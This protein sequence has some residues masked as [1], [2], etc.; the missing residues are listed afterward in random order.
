MTTIRTSLS[1]VLLFLH[2]ACSNS[3]PGLD[4]PAKALGA[5]LEGKQL[6]KQTFDE[7]FREFDA[8]PDQAAGPA[9]HRWRTVMGYGGPAAFDNRKISVT[10]IGVDSDFPGV[11]EGRLRTKTLGLNPFEHGEDKPL[12][13][14]ARPT[15]KELLPQLWGA[16]YYSG[17]ITTKFSFSQRYGY[18]EVEAK[19]PK[20]KGMWPSFWLLPVSAQWPQGGEIDVFEGL[21]DARSIYTTLHWGKQH[22]QTQ[23]K[24]D[25]PFDV[26]ADFHRYGVAWTRDAIVWY[27]DRREVMRTP[28]PDEVQHP[29]FLLLNLG[30]GG[31]WG[32]YPDQSTTFPGRYSIRRV[33]VWTL[34]GN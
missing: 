23:R 17:Q 25:L 14:L 2:A 30:V 27:V 34:S 10:S 5:V 7:T 11:E 4:R 8:G 26:S 24:I 21:G 1:L 28:T 16:R 18:F 31:P 22:K 32:G 9:P 12:T 3:P 13:I 6:G 15:P 20:G 29:M 33:Q 19:L